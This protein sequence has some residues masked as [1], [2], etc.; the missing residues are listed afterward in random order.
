MPDDIP[1][2]AH[3]ILRAEVLTAWRHVAL[4][5]PDG[6]E[7][8]RLDVLTDPHCSV[9]EVAGT[10]RIDYQVRLRGDDPDWGGTLPVRIYGYAIYDVPA[11]GTPYVRRPLSPAIF[12][13]ETDGTILTLP[14]YIPKTLIFR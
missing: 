13:L 10:G 14:V 9:N 5:D 7:L 4:E 12:T 2:P 1:P 6:R 3:A 11:G 8:C